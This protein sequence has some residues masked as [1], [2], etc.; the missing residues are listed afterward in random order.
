MAIDEE[1]AVVVW[2]EYFDLRR[3]RSQGRRVSKSLAIPNPTTESIA[4]ALARLGL[5]FKIEEEKAYPGNWFH[6]KGRALVENSMPKGELLR[7]IA[8]RMPRD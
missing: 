4:K 3:S 7:K 2:P 6:H 8:E 1:T 5:D